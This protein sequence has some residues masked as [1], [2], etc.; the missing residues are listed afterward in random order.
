MMV[1]VSVSVPVPMVMVVT[2]A[3]IMIM[4]V[5]VDVGMLL[6]VH[7]VDLGLLVT[8]QLIEQAVSDAVVQLLG[9]SFRQLSKRR[10]A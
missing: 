9:V 2:F 4:A 10:D 6:L 7:R 5:I 1:V 8:N 3:V